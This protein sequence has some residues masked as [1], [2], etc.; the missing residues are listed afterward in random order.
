MEEVT[1]K[2]ISTISA[3][4]GFDHFI[5]VPDRYSLIVE[6]M[7][8]DVL[9]IEATFTIKVLGINKL[10]KQIIKE[11]GL[12][13]FSYTKE[14]SLLFVRS[15]IN[16]VC[17]KF[18][19]FKKQ[20]STGFSEEVFSSISQFK[21]NKLGVEDIKNLTQT[22]NVS[23][24]EKLFDL[25]LI[26]E[27]YEKLLNGKLDA[28]EVLNVF[29]NLVENSYTV[30]NSYFY[31]V[32]FDS[33]TKQGYS[34]ITK[35]AKYSKGVTTSAMVAKNQKNK[36][37][38]DNEVYNNLSSF[39]IENNIGLKII[40]TYSDQKT[41]KNHIENN[42]Y[43]STPEILTCKNQP[44]FITES[45]QIEDEVE[46]AI[47]SI[48]HLLFKGYKFKDINIACP[49]EKYS[50]EI[51]KQLEQMGYDYYMD[52]TFD[53]SQ[54]Y[55][56][57]AIIS[58]LKFYNKFYEKNIFDVLKNNY[59]FENFEL[60][61]KMENIAIKNNLK[62]PF[63]LNY[64]FNLSEEENI[65]IKPLFKNIKTLF[66]EFINLNNILDFIIFIKKIYILFNFKEKIEKKIINL[67][68]FN[69]KI[70]KIYLQFE[71]AFGEVLQTF[72]LIE[73][74]IVS[75]EEFIELFIFSLKNK[76]INTIPLKT[77][78]I[79]V[80]DANTGFFENREFLFVLGANQ[81][82]VPSVLNDCGVISDKEIEDIK[83]VV[84][85]TPTI[86]MINRR[87][88][89]KVYDLL[90]NFNNALYVSYVNQNSDGGKAFASNFISSLLKM[91]KGENG[92]YK[93]HYTNYDLY[94]PE[95]ILDQNTYLKLEYNLLNLSSLKFALSKLLK[96]K[97]YEL[98]KIVYSLIKQNEHN[99]DA[100]I[101]TVNEKPNIENAK[102]LFFK[103]N[104]TK[105][106]QL[107]KYFHCP[108]EHFLDYGLRLVER[109]QG[110]VEARFIGTLLH[111]VAEIF[112]KQNKQTLGALSDEQVKKLAKNIVEE[113]SRQEE[114]SWILFEENKYLFIL[115]QKE[116]K[117]LCLK[118][119]QQQ[120]LSSFVPEFFEK[121][122]Y[123]N[124]NFKPLYIDDLQLTGV[125][126]RIDLF[127][128]NK[129]TY[130]R[131][132]D[133]KTGNIDASLSSVYFGNKIQ[134]F[135]Y[136]KAIEKSFNYKV[137]GN[138]Y[139]SIKDKFESKKTSSFNYQGVLLNDINI[140]TKMDSSV[141]FDKPASEFLPF[142]I[143]CS[144]KNIE[145]GEMVTIKSQNLLS[146]EDFDNI[147]NYVLNLSK[148]AIEEIKCGY[149][150][151]SPI[152]DECKFCKYAYACGFSNMLNNKERKPKS[153]N[154][155]LES[156]TG[157]KK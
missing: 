46:F 92:E 24:K 59:Y 44:V 104:K 107:E 22:E 152:K 121:R 151:T 39:A 6:S 21:T 102:E 94:F 31:F 12:D 82:L 109:E 134:L 7:L 68:N 4:D 103:N 148:K 23:M 123:E 146:I 80:G 93:I 81:D 58:L 38:F 1:K 156:F 140:L 154:V 13:D 32:G 90:T 25:A 114:N 89:F 79:F 143:S 54:M 127:K 28:S 141:N 47:K 122:F 144:K 83:N 18:T 111:S 91:F 87:R 147:A 153:V 14:Q 3:S 108:Y 62:F 73:N 77:N 50:K 150:Q 124:S 135:I 69:L 129:N 119:N 51:K 120:K 106:S 26:Y 138:L 97:N 35:L 37:L 49:L 36:F 115:L 60:I 65:L 112:C 117:N 125:V 55:V 52:E 16:S 75:A 84:S 29:E 5:I 126:D 72:S 155:E 48:K 61:E 137:A 96:N 57:D 74:Q 64:D 128:D 86:A 70:Q 142:K 30:Q 33:F 132:I 10:A 145:N 113:L 8:F 56:T 76:N 139:F 27:E 9:N 133:Y 101:L 2:V 105:I 45:A 130:F 100:Q 66:D 149:I 136:Q 43:L 63:L 71:S 110:D 67:E 131:V 19:C 116:S 118:L 40:E 98:A 11:C 85:I 157:D 95:N 34:L 15:A 99:F 41:I 78:S 17:D 42:L 88:R 20:L 53:L